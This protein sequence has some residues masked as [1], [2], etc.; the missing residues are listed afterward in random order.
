[1]TLG[2]FIIVCFALKCYAQIIQGRE[3]EP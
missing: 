2:Q 3:D 1:M